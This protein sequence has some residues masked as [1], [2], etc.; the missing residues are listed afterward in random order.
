MPVSNN[1]EMRFCRN[2]GTLIL[3]VM[4]SPGLP[5]AT[6]TGAKRK[7]AQII[8]KP[9]FG[10]GGFQEKINAICVLGLNVINDKVGSV[11]G[12]DNFLSIYK[13]FYINVI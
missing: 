3:Y 11:N 6:T 8:Q 2:P 1:H 9:R 10:S 5:L 13:R 4:S 12:I 7:V